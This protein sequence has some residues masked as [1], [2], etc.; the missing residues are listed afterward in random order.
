MARSNQVDTDPAGRAEPETTEAQ[1][2]AQTGGTLL[3]VKWPVES[4]RLPGEKGDGSDDVVVTRKPAPFPKAKVDEIVSR[5]KKSG[6][7]ILTVEEGK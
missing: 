7:T 6:V 5:A 1:G 4:F 3:K 2:T